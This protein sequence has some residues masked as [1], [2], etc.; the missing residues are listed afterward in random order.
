MKPAWV[1]RQLL[2]L[3]PKPTQRREVVLVEN[4]ANPSG[5]NNNA[6]NPTPV[7]RPSVTQTTDDEQL[8]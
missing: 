5:A 4:P 7:V 3:P 1:Q 8:F 6:V 2:T